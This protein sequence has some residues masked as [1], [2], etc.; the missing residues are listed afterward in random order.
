MQI[1]FLVAFLPF[2]ALA[3]GPHCSVFLSSG[4]VFSQGSPGTSSPEGQIKRFHGSSIHELRQ[5]IPLPP[6]LD[7]WMIYV[8][9][10]ESL[11]TTHQ[12]YISSTGFAKDAFRRW[13]QNWLSGKEESF[14]S[15]ETG[16]RE[17]HRLAS[18]IETG[19]PYYVKNPGYGSDTIQPGIFLAEIKRTSSPY[20]INAEAHGHVVEW[21]SAHGYVPGSPFSSIEIRG[22]KQL[23]LERRRTLQRDFISSSSIDLAFYS[24]SKDTPLVRELAWSRLNEIKDLVLSLRKQGTLPAQRAS[25]LNPLADYFHTSMYGHF[26]HKINFSL[27]MGEVNTILEE[28]GYAPVRHGFIDLVSIRMDYLPFREYFKEYLAHI[29]SEAPPT[30]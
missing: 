5:T 19:T 21:L 2:L 12:N 29:H 26:F 25:V 22:L 20:E 6:Y 17:R 4:Q 3:G 7:A 27:L 1:L 28:I 9:S 15:W 10:A 13:W 24:P 23:A 8:R 11:E 30:P 14:E 16:L 18:G